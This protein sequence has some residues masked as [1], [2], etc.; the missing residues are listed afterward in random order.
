MASEKRVITNDEVLTEIGTRMEADPA[1]LEQ[2][3]QNPVETLNALGVEVPAGV[4]VRI[5]AAEEGACRL[6][7]YRSEGSELTDEDLA[8]VAGGVSMPY[9]RLASSRPFRL[10]E[11]LAATGELI[12]YLAV[13]V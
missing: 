4:M 9:T 2:L 13:G 12:A 6:A 5:E 11:G 8:K 10:A 1:F 3:R 7:A